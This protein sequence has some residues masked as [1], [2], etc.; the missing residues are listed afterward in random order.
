M[1]YSHPAHIPNG[2]VLDFTVQAAN[3][4]ADNFLGWNTDGEL[5]SFSSIPRSRVSGGGNVTELTSAVLTITGGTAAVLTSGLTIQVQ[6]ADA[7]HSGYLSSADWN[8]FNNKPST[9][10]TSA[11]LYVGNG[12]NVATDVAV[13]GDIAITNAGVTSIA[14]GVIVNA[15]I[16]ATA[17]IALTKLAASTA[18]RAAV[19]DGSGFLTFSTTT[20][21]QIGYLSTLTSNVQTQLNAKDTTILGLS[22]AGVATGAGTDG[23]AI[24]WD[25][26]AN[27]WTL[28]PIGSGGSV[29]GP[30]S[31]TST[32]I[33]RWNGIGGTSLLNSGVLID[34]SNNIT[35][36]N[37][38][39]V[40]NSGIRITDVSTSYYMA[41]AA[42][43]TLT[44]ARTV[45]LITGDLDRT[46]TLT[47]NPVLDDWFDQDVRTG[48]DTQFNSVVAGNVG[49]LRVGDVS[50]SFYMLITT[51]S[52]YTANRTLTLVTGD[53]SRTLTINASG[54][55]YVTGG[56]DVSL[57]DGGTG[58]SL[59]DPGANTLMGWDDTDNTVGF[60]TLG[61]G[62]TYTH[63]SHTLSASGGGG[64]WAVTGTTTLTGNVTITSGASH[65]TTDF[66]GTWTAT[67][68]NDYH[69]N[70]GGSFT[71][72]AGNAG[73]TLTGYEFTPTLT[74]GTNGQTLN[75]V[76]I[77]PTFSG[78]G[79]FNP[80]RV[81]N[82]SS[83]L[84][85]IDSLGNIAIAKNN[86]QNGY[87][88]VTTLEIGTSGGM[89]YGANSGGNQ[90]ALVSNLN[91]DGGGFTH[92]LGTGDG[93]IQYFDGTGMLLLSAPA[94]TINS[95]A[96][97]TT[98]LKIETAGQLT[99][100][101]GPLTNASVLL[102]LQ[103]TTMAFV[104]TRMTTTQKNAIS[105]IT[106][107]MI[108]YDS[109]L[110]Q[111]QFRQSGAWSA[112][113]LNGIT[114]DAAGQFYGDQSKTRWYE[115]PL[116]EHTAATSG[117]GTIITSAEI[118]N[119]ESVC[120][121][122]QY[123]FKDDGSNAGGGGKSISNWTKAAGTL[124]K[125][126]EL[127]TLNGN[128]TGSVFTCVTSDSSGTIIATLTRVAG[129]NISWSW[130]AKIIHRK[131]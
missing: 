46:I 128:D 55:I 125:N 114:S 41:I 29:T 105:T 95:S 113:G 2:L 111:H 30:G 77:N 10:L 54:T 99:L 108:L 81:Q 124:V 94:G 37:S 82:A 121:E 66:A 107:G 16:H 97:L 38:L 118:A 8:T 28:S 103:S 78:T 131:P 93:W 47:G 26:G 50:T 84:F 45:T 32:A 11:H 15:D 61:S 60:W 57:A 4:S 27:E 109:T 70:F 120:I 106:D 53:A 39:Q 126:W 116:S 88:A 67:S 51:S 90:F 122:I 115:R 98:R 19:Y 112:P 12:S 117:T 100:G 36:A 59:A 44:A 75:A 62:L 110:G 104:P 24:T 63:A 21:T 58:S 1:A 35:G 83:N 68:N 3:T 65:Y 52:T 119:G 72:R 64:G 130:I 49:G 89:I 9:T 25:N 6:Q 20:A 102:D 40:A 87:S 73:D 34:G 7:T 33:V 123:T 85:V 31:S 74:T 92:L 127:D 23:Y 80:L 13:T 96:T 69:M 48:A 17:G 76:L 14:A 91:V 22:G 42:G 101:P 5:T 18:S 43:D 71:G 79:N 129:G 86:P 56:T